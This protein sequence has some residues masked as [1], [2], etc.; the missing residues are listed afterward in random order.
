LSPD[1]SA[2]QR[3]IVFGPTGTAG[4][5]AV[6]A[7]LADPAITDV[8]AVTRR[9]LA[10]SHAK[11]REVRCA[12]FARVDEIAPHFADVQCCLFCLGT[13]V[14]NVKDEDEYREI[15]VTYALAAARA[16]RATSPDAAFIYLS[17]AGANR[18][19]RMM[20]ARVKAEAEDRLADI[21]LVRHANVRPAAIV[22]MHPT[23]LHRVLLAPLVRAIPALGIPSRDLGRAMLRL[24]VS[25]DWTGM[26]TLENRDLRELVSGP[27][28]RHS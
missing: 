3:V 26:R 7:C 4:A 12:D 25:R 13:S 28:R 19:S 22:P 14:R 16:L 5:G 2:E 20:W 11:L 24:G 8:R 6:S 21:G 18:T 23:G 9:S 17:G 15:H 10:V 1:P 27:G